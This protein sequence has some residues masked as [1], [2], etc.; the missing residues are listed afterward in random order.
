MAAWKATSALLPNSKRVRLRA[1]SDGRLLSMSYHNLSDAEAE[2][3]YC[4]LTS[5]VIALNTLA[6]DP[7]RIWKG[8]WR[9]YTEEFVSFKVSR[10]RHKL[11][12][13]VTAPLLVYSTCSW[14][15]V[16]R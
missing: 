15:V 13:I 7:L 11:Q 1:R 2:P 9:W 12:C 16:P 10:D 3:A 14:I 8:S 6:I 5:L 4:G